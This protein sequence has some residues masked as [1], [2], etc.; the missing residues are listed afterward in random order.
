MKKRQTVLITG[1]STGLGRAI[2]SVL[3]EQGHRVFGTSRR[4]AAAASTHFPLLELD[5]RYDESATHC[6]K[7]V[8]DDAGRIDVLINNAAYE[9]AGGLEETTLAE[10]E[11]QFATNFFGVARMN[12]AVLPVMRAQGGGRII[13][14]GSLAGLVGVPFHGYYSASKHA[15]EGYTEALRHEVSGFNIKVSI[16]E[17]GFMATNLA[18][19]SHVIASAIAEYSNMRQQA[20]DFFAKSFASGDD[21]LRAARVISSII[22]DEDPRLQYRVGAMTTWLPRIKGIMPQ[23]FFEKGLDRTFGLSTGNSSAKKH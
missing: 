4:P 7:T 16:V 5:V 17:P 20:F 19:A 22:D 15:L 12:K 10:A 14:I 9:L 3:V 18:A 13:I 6:L 21:P 1:A 2:A 23:K 11:A 8:M